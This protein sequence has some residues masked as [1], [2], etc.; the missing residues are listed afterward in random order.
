MRFLGF[1]HALVTNPA[2]IAG[3]ASP[4]SLSWADLALL[5]NLQN[6]LAEDGLPLSEVQESEEP[7]NDLKQLVGGLARVQ[8]KSPEAYEKAVDTAKSGVPHIYSFLPDI[9]VSQNESV[10]LKNLSTLIHEV[11]LVPIRDIWKDN[12]ETQLQEIFQVVF[13]VREKLTDSDW[14]FLRQKAWTPMEVL[15]I[16]FLHHSQALSP[17]HWNEFLKRPNPKPL[18]PTVDIRFGEIKIHDLI[19]GVLPHPV[20]G[21]LHGLS[22]VY[23]DFDGQE[24]R[25]GAMRSSQIMINGAFLM[26]GASQLVSSQDEVEIDG[27]PANIGVQTIAVEIPLTVWPEYEVAREDDHP[28][29]AT[30][31]KIELPYLLA[32]SRVRK[33][34]PV[35][36]YGSNYASEC[37]YDA[38]QAPKYLIVRK[39]NGTYTVR[40]GADHHYQMITSGEILVAGGRLWLNIWGNLE[41]NTDTK[42][43]GEVMCG[44]FER[45]TIARKLFKNLHPQGK[46]I[47]D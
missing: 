40:I 23:I 14:T 32:K 13:S 25:I 28:Y 9:S 1:A 7:Q 38:S 43:F 27:R 46:L 10:S 22:G 47:S 19:N 33:I 44:G 8:R 45:L 16:D 21:M 4:Y 37:Y 18:N 34:T 30:A 35:G 2:C 39:P 31:T 41:S 11:N 24:I 5:N 29:S 36:P 17:A 6:S 12:V 42:R 26:A 15:F 20:K 3:F